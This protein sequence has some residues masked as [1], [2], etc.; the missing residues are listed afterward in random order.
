MLYVEKNGGLVAT[1]DSELKG[2]IKRGG[3]SV[4]SLA[5]DRIV[6]EP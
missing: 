3:G 6:L 2:R 4:I 5:S 1:I